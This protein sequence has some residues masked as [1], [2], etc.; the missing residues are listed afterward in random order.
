MDHTRQDAD[1]CQ[2]QRAAFNC[3]RAG[4]TENGEGLEDVRHG[5]VT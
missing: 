3:A 4:H 1:W 5:H 2:A